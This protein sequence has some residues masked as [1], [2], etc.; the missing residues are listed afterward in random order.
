MSLR[1]RGVGGVQFDMNPKG[2]PKL[3]SL[4]RLRYCVIVAFALTVG[5]NVDPPIP[6]NLP[7]PPKPAGAPHSRLRVRNVGSLAIRELVIM[8]PYEDVRFGDV[9]NG[10]T[11]RYLDVPRGVYSLAAIR[12]SWGP[13]GRPITQGVTDWLGE[14]PLPVGDFT[15]ELRAEPYG[16]GSIVYLLGI[17]REISLRSSVVPPF[18]SRQEAF[19]GANRYRVPVDLPRRSAE[20]TRTNPVG[21]R[22]SGKLRWLKGSRRRNCADAH[23]RT[24]EDAAT[25][26]V[27]ARRSA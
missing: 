26:S 22:C 16:D 15:Y 23:R 7:P 18:R 14:R 2:A 21:C 3:G 13:Q 9:G 4:N 20:P 24:R 17:L 19:R 6:P 12:H 1:V 5:C 27:T 8:F 25:P 11:T 10:T